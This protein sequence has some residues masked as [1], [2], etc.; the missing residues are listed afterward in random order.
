ML[1]QDISKQSACKK[2][3]IKELKYWNKYLTTP[4]EGGIYTYLYSEVEVPDAFETIFWERKIG[5]NYGVTVQ[6]EDTTSMQFLKLALALQNI[7]YTDCIDPITRSDLEEYFGKPTFVTKSFLAHAKTSYNYSFNHPDGNS[8]YHGEYMGNVA[9]Q[10]CLTI[11]MEIDN[12][13][14]VVELNTS[15]F[16]IS[17]HR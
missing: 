16:E 12:K 7:V 15:S 13:D 1:N 6:V 2:E 8:C 14:K 10:A 11:I 3:A 17:S 9:Y 4:S 5:R